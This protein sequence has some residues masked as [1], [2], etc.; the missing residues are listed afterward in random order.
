M[1]RMPVLRNVMVYFLS[2]PPL[3]PYD[4]SDGFVPFNQMRWTDT[5]PIQEP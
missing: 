4:L 1:E 2:S 3:T 5:D